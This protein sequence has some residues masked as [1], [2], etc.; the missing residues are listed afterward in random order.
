M[1]HAVLPVFPAP[2]EAAAEAIRHVPMKS[3]SPSPS[4]RCRGKNFAVGTW[5]R[6][7]LLLLE[8]PLRPVP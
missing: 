7:T 1:D 4:L 8:K 5:M 2:T 3:I 6:C